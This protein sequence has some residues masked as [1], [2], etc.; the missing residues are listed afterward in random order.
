MFNVFG[1]IRIY[2]TYLLLL[3]VVIVMMCLA[4]AQLGEVWATSASPFGELY[5]ELYTSTPS[6]FVLME[7]RTIY[8][9]F[10][11]GPSENTVRILDILKEEDV[12]A[13]FFVI[14]KDD[15]FSKGLIKRMYDEGHTVGM[16][17][18]VH[19]Y[20]KIYASVE[21]YLEDLDAIHNLI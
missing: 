10:D 2:R 17:C 13:T 21:G 18:N 9:T 19:S 6:E 5:P 3:L 16:H 11:D 15:D 12:K 14:G 1:C 4:V 7:E 20:P 8:L